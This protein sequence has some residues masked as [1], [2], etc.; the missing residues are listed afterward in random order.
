MKKTTIKTVLASV[1]MLS[2]IAGMTLMASCK[3][4]DSTVSPVATMSLYDSLGS[5]TMVTDP[6]A[7]TTKI[8]KGRLALRSVVDSTIFVI[9]VDTSINNEFFSVLLSEVKVGNT[10]GFSALSKNL[11]DFFCYATGAKNF[12]YGGKSMKAAHDPA[13]NSRMGAKADATDF[14]QF[15]ADLV[16]GAKKNGV[17]DDMI[18]NHI[19]PL[20]YTL[21]TQVVQK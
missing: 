9:A 12:T 20:V 8:E 6:A 14:D 15:V 10:T 7:P 4:S 17:S 11:T 2:I 13:Q 5:T 21:K 3:K 1:A 16:K 19:G 18:N